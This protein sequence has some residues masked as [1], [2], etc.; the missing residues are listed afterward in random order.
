MF[1]PELD[2][3]LK[4]RREPVSNREQGPCHIATILYNLLNQTDI[5]ALGA[6]GFD[7]EVSL[8]ATS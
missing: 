5:L 2:I 4:Q 8:L 1:A 7:I 6:S 3:R